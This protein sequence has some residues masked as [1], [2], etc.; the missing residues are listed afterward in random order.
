MNYPRHRY[1]TLLVCGLTLFLLPAR[2]E[3]QSKASPS[4]V[5]HAAFEKINVTSGLS[6]WKQE[7]TND[8][9]KHSN[10]PFEC[11]ETEEIAEAFLCQFS[12]LPEMNRALIRATMFVEGTANHEVGAIPSWGESATAMASQMIAGH[13]L[14]GDALK[15]FYDKASAECLSQ[16]DKCLSQ[17]EK[18]FYAK[19]LPEIVRTRE[20]LV[21]IA[22]AAQSPVAPEVVVSHEIMH[23]QYFLQPRYRQIADEFWQNEVS[24]EDKRLV[25]L[26][27]AD[28]YNTSDE[29]LVKNEFQA[30][31]LMRGADFEKLGT[32][33]RKYRATFM[34]QFKEAELKEI[35]PIQVQ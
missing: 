8:L 31:L 35:Y 30:Y 20:S 23:A 19:M 29:I 27:L 16:P 28:E 32:L 22:F 4:S 3:D 6:S 25:K 17:E 21:V 10:A 13:D 7:Y 33:A 26:L 2:G 5:V 24:E 1:L 14:R 11:R 18:L 9:T 12:S 34:Q 15:R